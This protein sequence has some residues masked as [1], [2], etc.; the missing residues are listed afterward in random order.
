[1]VVSSALKSQSGLIGDRW[2]CSVSEAI[3]DEVGLGAQVRICRDADH[4]AVYTVTEI[5][6]GD[7]ADMLRLGKTGRER[8]GTSASGYA[9]TLRQALATKVMSESKAKSAGEFVERI[10]DDGKH[11]GL[12]VL[13]PHGGSIEI[14]TDRQARRVGD[15][16]AG[17]DVSTWCCNGYKQGGGAFDR[18]HVT[19]TLI[20]TTSFPGLAQVTQR[21]Y[22]YSV[23][24]H[25]M[26]ASGVL[27]GG[28]GPMQLKQQVKQEI[29]AAL[30]G[31]AGPVTIA[32]SGQSLGGTAADN[33]TNWVTAGGAGGIQIEQSY[34]IRSEYWQDVADAVACVFA[35][36]V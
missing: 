16:L 7:P 21:D 6:A 8:L 31:D 14:N 32:K 10:C 36:M 17:A 22:A 2:A 35:K 13:A 15:V 33:V 20:N 1:M 12:L 11:Q 29:E 24:F 26:S 34:K 25:G 30:G 19:S 27:I 5:R 18:W 3:A 28:S 23:A 9:A 4:C